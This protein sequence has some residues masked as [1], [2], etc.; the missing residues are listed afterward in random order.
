MLNF[1]LGVMVCLFGLLVAAQISQHPE[2]G[3]A[4]GNGFLFGILVSAAAHKVI[5]WW[6]TR[7]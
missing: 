1:V 6:V 3:G 2:M 7:R 4:A 5:L